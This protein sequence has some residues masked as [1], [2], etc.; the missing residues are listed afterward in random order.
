MGSCRPCVRGIVR[1]TPWS[2]LVRLDLGTSRFR[3]RA[4]QAATLGRSSAAAKAYSI[5]SSPDLERRK[6]EIEFLI[7]TKRGGRFGPQLAGLTV[8]SAVSLTGPFGTFVLPEPLRERRLLFI[9]GG[10][11][12][13]PLRSMIY[14]ALARRNP[15][16]ITL[17]YS[18]QSPDGFAFVQ[19][20]RRLSRAG[21]LCLRLTATR[22]AGRAW[23]GR[24]GRIQTS[25]LRQ[26]LRAGPTL[27]F[28][29][30]QPAFVE[31]VS[32]MLES[33]GLPSTWIKREG[34]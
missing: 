30:G 3:F 4:G 2:A 13:A 14:S 19:E 8:G 16:A 34:Y 24:R 25:W 18:A 31:N 27:C 6:H 21:R 9:A 33:L 11:G 1:D 12:I 22:K 5:A 7:G 20:F 17:L 15:A 23:R 10:T 28:V 32:G 26:L 29:C